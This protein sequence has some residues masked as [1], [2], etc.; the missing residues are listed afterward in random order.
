M[1]LVHAL[2]YRITEFIFNLP[3]G[4]DPVYSYAISWLST[5]AWLA[6]VIEHLLPQGCLLRK[7]SVITDGNSCHISSR[8]LPPFN[9]KLDVRCKYQKTSAELTVFGEHIA[10]YPKTEP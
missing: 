3:Q 2:E 1:F 8:T 9:V 4:R 7:W 5:T 10:S 6:P